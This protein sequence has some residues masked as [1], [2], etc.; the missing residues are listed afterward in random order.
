VSP[1][2]FSHVFWFF[3]AMSFHWS[4]LSSFSEWVC[5]SYLFYAFPLPFLSQRQ[6]DVPPHPLI[7][8]FLSVTDFL[9]AP[10]V[11]RVPQGSRN[12]R[13]LCLFIPPRRSSFCALPST[14][15]DPLALP[16]PLRAILRTVYPLVFFLL[17]LWLIVHSEEV[18]TPLSPSSP[19]LF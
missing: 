1:L 5:S 3:V 18:I 14:F 15:L 19:L 6:C 13:L 11:S 16:K 7:W 12:L 4:G 17:F 9:N 10:A 2:P 8:S